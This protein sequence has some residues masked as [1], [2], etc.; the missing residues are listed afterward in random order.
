MLGFTGVAFW[1][2]ALSGASPANGGTHP[3]AII[4]RVCSMAL[5]QYTPQMGIVI[6][7]LGVL[8]SVA[9][10]LQ[11]PGAVGTLMGRRWGMLLLR[12]IGYTKV[13]SYIAA[14]L[15][16]GLALFS[17]VEANRPTWTFA[18]INWL[19]SIAMIGVYYWII[20][21]MNRVLHAGEPDALLD[22]Q[23]EDLPPP[24]PDAFTGRPVGRF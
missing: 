20:V 7:V 19:A 23:D 9:S 13:A 21:A 12:G 14:G 24:G 5:E 1:I 10:A 18:A 2:P 11:I 22:L 17:S 15:L 4:Q 3:V 6:P 16:L 8:F